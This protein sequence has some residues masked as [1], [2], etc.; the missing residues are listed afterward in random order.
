MKDLLF[1]LTRC[2]DK[3]TQE[4]LDAR[5]EDDLTLEIEEE[6]KEIRIFRYLQRHVNSQNY[7]DEVN[8]ILSHSFDNRDTFVL[9]ALSGIED[10][11][12]LAY[13]IQYLTRNDCPILTQN[14]MY[15]FKY[16][17]TNIS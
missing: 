5:F 16:F 12:T 2:N 15:L 4:Y 10:D 17:S 3:R 1:L 13:L 11:A 6:L 14:I 8:S 9:S 7:R